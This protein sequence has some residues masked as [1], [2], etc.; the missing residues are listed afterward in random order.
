[1]VNALVIENQRA[2]NIEE[3]SDA[4]LFFGGAVWQ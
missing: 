2:V 1:M 4:G 3:E